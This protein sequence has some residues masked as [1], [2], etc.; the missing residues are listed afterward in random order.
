MTCGACLRRPP[1][2]DSTLTALRYAYPV[3]RMVRTLKYGGA[4][5]QGRVLGELLASHLSMRAGAWPDCVV[6]VPLARQRFQQRGYNQAI[7]IAGVLAKRLPISLR[8]DLVIRTRETRE[9]A[10]L[11]RKER[12][13]NLR[14][15]F[16]VRAALP[17]PHV[18]IVDDVITTGSTMNEVARVLKRAGAETVEA[19]A[20]ARAGRLK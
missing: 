20:V 7:E 12:R 1:H 14:N 19:W 2:V 15:A 16:A 11:D 6:P 18:A 9:Q 13:R 17:G 8:T 10:E 5:V 4:V 3:D